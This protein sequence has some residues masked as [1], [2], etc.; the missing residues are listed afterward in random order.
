MVLPILMGCQFGVEGLQEWL[1][2]IEQGHFHSAV[3]YPQTL[4]CFVRLSDGWLP[5]F[6]HGYPGDPIIHTASW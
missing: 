4:T 1:H 6:L 3:L 2:I 5:F